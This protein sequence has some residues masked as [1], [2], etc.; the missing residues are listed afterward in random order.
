M[1][2]A[3]IVVATRTGAHL[4][5]R[6]TAPTVMTG[7]SLQ[8]RNE[9]AAILQS[10]LDGVTSVHLSLSAIQIM[11]SRGFEA[12]VVV[13]HTCRDRGITLTCSR[14]TEMFRQ[15]VTRMGLATLFPPT[16]SQ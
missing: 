7:E 15:L 4:E 11:S 12:L 1:D 13:H 10:Q 5:L 8:L 3:S 16:D 9:V 6:V 2:P 14:Q